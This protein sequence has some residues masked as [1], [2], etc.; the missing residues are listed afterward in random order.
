MRE[1]FNE[2]L[3]VWNKMKIVREKMGEA[4]QLEESSELGDEI[5]DRDLWLRMRA[6]GL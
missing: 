3:E 1:Y 4:K 6:K 2:L 5:H